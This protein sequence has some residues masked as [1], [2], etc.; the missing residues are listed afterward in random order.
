MNKHH[1]KY[2]LDFHLLLDENLVLN[3]HYCSCCFLTSAGWERVSDRRT[4]VGESERL[5]LVAWVGDALENQVISTGYE[6]SGVV[7][8]RDVLRG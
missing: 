6:E 7:W 1:R 4:R 3:N 2:V 8:R 5:F